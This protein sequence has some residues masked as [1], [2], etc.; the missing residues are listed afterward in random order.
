[1]VL[2]TN[3]NGVDTNLQVFQEDKDSQVFYGK[4]VLYNADGPQI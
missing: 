2:F 4:D 1:M 3:I